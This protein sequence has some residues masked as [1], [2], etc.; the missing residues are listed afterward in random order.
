MIVTSVMYQ[1]I[2]SLSS[3]DYMKRGTHTLHQLPELTHWFLQ[4]RQCESSAPLLAR[5]TV[6]FRVFQV[7]FLHVRPKRCSKHGFPKKWCTPKAWKC[8]WQSHGPSL[9]KLPRPEAGASRLFGKAPGM[10]IASLARTLH[11]F[12]YYIYIWFYMY[13]HRRLSDYW[14]LGLP[15]SIAFPLN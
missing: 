9:P 14:A 6:V 10:T 11:T 2:I 3:P 7:L 1:E 13:I 12:I 5:S 8:L 15:C 4:G